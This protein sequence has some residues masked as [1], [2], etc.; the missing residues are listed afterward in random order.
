M[1]EKIPSDVWNVTSSDEGK[2]AINTLRLYEEKYF[3]EAFAQRNP[4]LELIK[5]SEGQRLFAYT[6]VLTHFIYRYY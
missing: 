4:D 1:S 2:L 3:V 6:V 5:L